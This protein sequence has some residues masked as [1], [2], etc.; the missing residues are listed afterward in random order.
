MRNAN[1]VETNNK[2]WRTVSA[3]QSLVVYFTLR[4][5][6]VIIFLDIVNVSIL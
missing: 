5:S 1:S 6:A 3:V 4:N 2:L